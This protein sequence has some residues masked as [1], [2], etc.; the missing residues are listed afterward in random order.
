MISFSLDSSFMNSFFHKF[1][2]T[3]FFVCQIISWYKISIFSI[4]AK[5]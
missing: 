4:N 5:R 2:N 3:F 1:R